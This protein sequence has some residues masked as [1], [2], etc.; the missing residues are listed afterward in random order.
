MLSPVNTVVNHQTCGL[1][2]LNVT[3]NLELQSMLRKLQAGWQLASSQSP[4]P[5]WVY[6][7]RTTWGRHRGWMYGQGLVAC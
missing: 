7:C 1:G 4:T 6:L 2:D 3:Y 5:F